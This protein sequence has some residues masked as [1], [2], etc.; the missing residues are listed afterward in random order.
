MMSGSLRSPF[1]STFARPAIAAMAIAGA[2]AR[3]ASGLRAQPAAAPP[4]P[5]AVAVPASNP[6]TEAL[7]A[8]VAAD[9]EGLRTFMQKMVDQV[10]SYGEL[11]FHETETSK[12]LTRVLEKN[13]FRIERNYAGMP[14]E[15]VATWGTGKPV[16]A[17]GSDID[18]IP[19]AS[20]KPGSG[21]TSAKPTTSTSKSCAT[22]ARRSRA[23]RR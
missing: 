12:Y 1:S 23:A 21:T 18:G 14:T 6:R 7:K 9:L 10:F 3:A 11:A 19:Q 2:T 22:S 5:P 16:I 17:L 4:A 20:Q 13:G 15:W 8:Q